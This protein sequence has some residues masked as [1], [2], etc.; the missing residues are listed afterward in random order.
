[1][2]A[3]ASEENGTLLDWHHLSA[4]PLRFEAFALEDLEAMIDHMP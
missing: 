1:M 4:E 2:I 3:L